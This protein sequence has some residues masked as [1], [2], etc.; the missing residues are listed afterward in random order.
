VYGLVVLGM[1]AF[2]QYIAVGIVLIIAVVVDQFGR[3]LGK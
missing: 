2:W 3:A 1:P